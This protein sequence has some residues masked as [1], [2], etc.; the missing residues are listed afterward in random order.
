MNAR[1]ATDLP[2][3]PF[4]NFRRIARMVS[5]ELKLGTGS[6][7]VY[8]GCGYFLPAPEAEIVQQSNM[9]VGDGGSTVPVFHRSLR[10]H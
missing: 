9:V 5:A 3:T 6:G 1:Q 10:L 7:G 4:N 8:D 2:P